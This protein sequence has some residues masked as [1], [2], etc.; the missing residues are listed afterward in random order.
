M[1]VHQQN[2]LAGRPAPPVDEL[3]AAGVRAGTAGPFRPYAVGLG[4]PAAWHSWRAGRALDRAAGAARNKTIA[5]QI[6]AHRTNDQ[7]IREAR[8]ILAEA[9]SDRDLDR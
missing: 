1:T 4:L 2:L 8:V 3:P 6:T 5:H 7:M 9:A